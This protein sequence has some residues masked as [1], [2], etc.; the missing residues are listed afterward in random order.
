MKPLFLLAG[1]GLSMLATFGVAR[2]IVHHFDASNI[3]HQEKSLYRNI[4]VTEGDGYRCMKFGRYDARQT[5][6]AIAHPSLLILNY[7][8]GILTSLYVASSPRRVLILGL[9]GGA[10]PMALRSIDPTMQIESVELDPAVVKI[11]RSHFGYREDDHSH[12]HVDDARVF[13]RKQRRQGELYDLVIL[14]AFDKDYIPEHLLTREFLEEVRSLLTPQGAVAANTFASG[15][16]VQHEAA[17][18]QAVF[19]TTYHVDMDNGNRIILARR[20]ELPSP[21]QIRETA[22]LLDEKIKPLG[23]SAADLLPRI[24]QSAPV[25]GVRVLTDQFSPSNLL[26]RQR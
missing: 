24:K 1:V 8:R 18:Y 5:C 4:F 21:A 3:V 20:D 2:D 12:A 22:L 23:A 13:V 10:I 11:A 26:I 25:S 17:T 15:P 7:T 6:I 19:G 14:D 16:L 9:G